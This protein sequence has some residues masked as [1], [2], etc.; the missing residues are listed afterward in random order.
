MAV[1]ARFRGLRSRLNQSDVIVIKCVLTGTWRRRIPAIIRAVRV[2]P[3]FPCC[4][5]R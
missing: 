3:Y 1:T 4:R 2:C 5:G